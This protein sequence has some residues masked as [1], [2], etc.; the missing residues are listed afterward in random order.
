VT[1]NAAEDRGADD[2][3]TQGIAVRNSGVNIE[4]VTAQTDLGDE[5]ADNNNYGLFV[6]DEGGP[7]ENVALSG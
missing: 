2:Y 6:S 1:R 4:D 5:G 7:T 3:E